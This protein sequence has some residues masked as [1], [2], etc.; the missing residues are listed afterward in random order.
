VD[1][2]HY[3]ELNDMNSPQPIVRLIKSRNMRWACDVPCMKEENSVQVF[4][5]EKDH[6]EDTGVD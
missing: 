5:G 1:K 6:I 2:L 4:G 3:K